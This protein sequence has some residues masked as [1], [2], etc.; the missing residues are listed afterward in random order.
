MVGDMLH[1]TYQLH[2]FELGARQLPLRIATLTVVARAESAALDWEVVAHT[3]EREPVAQAPHQIAMWS[4]NGV[5]DD[6][7]LELER[8]E[9]EAI[10]VRAV[11]TA[12]VFRGVGPL[13][14]FDVASLRG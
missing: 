9:G 11:D 10:L 1:A 6:G 13:D 5:D 7:R 3:I 8:F 14:G 12:L 2:S 4:I